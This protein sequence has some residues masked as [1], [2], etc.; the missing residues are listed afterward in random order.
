MPI[1][2]VCT[3][4]WA[5]TNNSNQEEDRVSTVN[6]ASNYFSFFRQARMNT[7][8]TAAIMSTP[9]TNAYSK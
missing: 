6:I 2:P 4:F 3:E 9:A 1:E 8:K 7:E 5:V